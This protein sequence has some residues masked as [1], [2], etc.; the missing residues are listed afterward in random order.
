[1]TYDRWV[2]SEKVQNGTRDRSVV[3]YHA[4]NSTNHANPIG[5]IPNPDV[6]GV[7]G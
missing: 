5:H 1:M 4:R 7:S 3:R 6:P 2:E